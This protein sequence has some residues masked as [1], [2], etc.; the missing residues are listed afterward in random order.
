MKHSDCVHPYF[1]QIG[2]IGNKDHIRF[3]YGCMGKLPSFLQTMAMW[4]MPTNE[5]TD[6]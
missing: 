5:I 6:T 1:I 2:D 4:E 3:K